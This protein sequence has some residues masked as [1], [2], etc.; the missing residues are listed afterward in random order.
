[1]KNPHRFENQMFGTHEKKIV[2]KTCA[3]I[4][5]PSFDGI[6]NHQKQKHSNFGKKKRKDND[7]D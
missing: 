3:K 5:T 2:R 7:D 6:F 1:M 4:Q